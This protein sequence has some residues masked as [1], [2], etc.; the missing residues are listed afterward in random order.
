MAILRRSAKPLATQDNSEEKSE[1]FGLG[2]AMSL[3]G[4]K[5]ERDRR[6]LLLKSVRSTVAPT[7]IG[8]LIFVGAFAGSTDTL[9]LVIWSAIALAAGLFRF[10]VSKKWSGKELDEVTAAKVHKQTIIGTVAAMLSWVLAVVL[11]F[12]HN[13]VEQT[14]VT[15]MMLILCA[16]G[17]VS[18]SVHKKA[19]LVY[20]PPLMA[21]LIIRFAIETF[22]WRAGES[23]GTL[24]IT[25]ALL[26]M[27][28]A[29]LRMFRQ[30]ETNLV[31]TLTLNYQNAGL[32]NE[33]TA[34]NAAIEQDKRDQERKREGLEQLAYLFEQG[35]SGILTHASEVSEELISAA[36]KTYGNAQSTLDQAKIVSRGAQSVSESIQTLSEAAQDLT[37]TIA[38][39]SREVNSAAE[40][41]SASVADLKRTNE[42]VQSL[43]EASLKVGQIVGLIT[44]IAEQTNLLALNATIEA[45]R[46]GEAGKGFAVVASEVKNLATQT[47]AA[48]QEIAAQI[49]TIQMVTNSAVSALKGIGDTIYRI[50]SIAES[51][52]TSVRQQGETTQSIS[53]RLQSVAA[54]TQMVSE[55]VTKVNTTANDTGKAAER[56]ITAAD[57]LATKT[58]EIKGE[59]TEFLD[60]VRDL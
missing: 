48:T 29:L 5:I 22:P 49:Q 23:G 43:T 53:E 8:I 13:P 17:T 24:A 12:S 1:K 37:T 36:D 41:A 55:N 16:G 38:D 10:M 2:E 4:D 3:H 39:V 14:I 7:L 28:V 25:F 44:S 59:V 26:L 56:M 15:V 34:S 6:A 40:I 11:F 52:A 42:T 30:S 31:Q 21:V 27:F 46:A 60:G 20:V 58:G 9:T 54:D 51:V 45:A 33:L 57:A 35:V 19:F 32:V 18:L 47:G 50:N